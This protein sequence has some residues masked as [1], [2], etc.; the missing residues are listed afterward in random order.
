VL[1]TYAGDID[2]IMKT[3]YKDIRIHPTIGNR[4][5]SAMHFCKNAYLPVPVP[6]SRTDF[7]T[8]ALFERSK[9]I[10]GTASCALAN[11]L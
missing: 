1:Q 9:L 8:M 6:T 2:D 7:D 10:N 4:G 3:K 11:L 5:L